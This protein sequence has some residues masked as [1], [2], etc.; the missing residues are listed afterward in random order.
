M[1]RKKK[2]M[3]KRSTNPLLY[4][5]PEP[6]IKEEPNVFKDPPPYGGKV[7][8]E[9]TSWNGKTPEQ[10]PQF[11]QTCPLTDKNSVVYSEGEASVKVAAPLNQTLEHM[12]N[13][14]QNFKFEISQKK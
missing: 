13:E 1:Q 11:D 9:D 12:M 5:K 3:N 2:Y 4:P 8:S 7:P 14:P 10:T 6:E